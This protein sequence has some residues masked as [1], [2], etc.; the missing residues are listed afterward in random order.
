LFHGFVRS[1]SF[2]GASKNSLYKLPAAAAEVRSP[3]QLIL[4]DVDAACPGLLDTA[5]EA[6]SPPR[7]SI[8]KVDAPA[9]SPPRLGNDEVDAACPRLPEIAIVSSSRDP[10]V[11]WILKDVELFNGVDRPTCSSF[12]DPFPLADSSEDL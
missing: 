1:S 6:F 10:V 3:P 11:I 8:E 12:T 9:C 4:E 7:L 2:F 5:A